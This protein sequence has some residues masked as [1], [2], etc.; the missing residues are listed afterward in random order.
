MCIRQS[1]DETSS[2]KTQSHTLGPRNGPIVPLWSWKWLKQGMGEIYGVQIRKQSLR[3]SNWRKREPGVILLLG[4]KTSYVCNRTGQIIQFWCFISKKWRLIKINQIG[5]FCYLPDQ[6]KKS[7][8]GDGG[9]GW[10]RI[11]KKNLQHRKWLKPQRRDR[12]KWFSNQI[13]TSEVR[14]QGE[15]LFQK[16]FLR[17]GHQQSR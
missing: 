13:L 15:K 1:T 3:S 12:K 8:M 4:T 5:A 14:V 16:G 11:K 7:R 6:M 17:R 9:R 2:T 10:W